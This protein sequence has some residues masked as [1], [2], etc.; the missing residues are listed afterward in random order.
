MAI[1][2]LPGIDPGEHAVGKFLKVRVHF[3]AITNLRC[4]ALHTAEHV[5]IFLG[6]LHLLEERNDVLLPENPLVLLPEGAREERVGAWREL[7]EASGEGGQ[8]ARGTG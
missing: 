3:E 8:D 5:L 1:Q 7:V 6:E 2:H 4:E